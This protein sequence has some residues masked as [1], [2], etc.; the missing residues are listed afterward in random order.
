[1]GA[2]AD[3]ATGVWWAQFGNMCVSCV[4]KILLSQMTKI[5]TQLLR[6]GEVVINN[7]ANPGDCVMGRMLWPIS[8]FLQEKIA[9]HEVGSGPRHLHRVA[10]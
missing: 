2:D 10:L 1:M 9:W 4:E 8:G 7:Q 5:R 3:P 6:H